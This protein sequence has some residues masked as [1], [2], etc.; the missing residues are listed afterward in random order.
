MQEV[1]QLT[2][3]LTFITDPC[4]ILSF[5]FRHEIS[6]LFAADCISLF[7]FFVLLLLQQISGLTSIVL[8]SHFVLNFTPSLFSHSLDSHSL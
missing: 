8:Q 3:L 2:S 6:L 5:L 4:N 7:F 1:K